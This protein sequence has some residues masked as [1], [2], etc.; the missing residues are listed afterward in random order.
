MLHCKLCPVPLY[1]LCIFYSIILFI[2]LIQLFFLINEYSRHLTNYRIQIFADLSNK[3]KIEKLI[4]KFCSTQRISYAFYASYCHCFPI[5]NNQMEEY[6][7]CHTYCIVPQ[8]L[9]EVKNV[10]CT[11]MLFLSL[12]KYRNTSRIIMLCAHNIIIIS[13]IHLN[14]CT[15]MAN[16]FHRIGW[17]WSGRHEQIRVDIRYHFKQIREK[18]MLQEW[19]PYYLVAHIYFVANGVDHADQFAVSLWSLMITWCALPNIH[20]HRV[21]VTFFFFFFFFF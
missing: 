9:L 2:L 18:V 15:R 7:V 16:H 17:R 5:S 1:F 10:V 12:P 13:I 8:H 3:V 4:I 6:T 19:A 14:G 21:N 11:F 20:I